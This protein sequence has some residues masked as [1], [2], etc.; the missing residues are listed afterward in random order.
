MRTMRIQGEQGSLWPLW[1]AVVCWLIVT[2][3][4]VSALSPDNATFS[5]GTRL[6]LREKARGMFY[7]GWDSYMDYAFPDDELR[8]LSC[9]G[10]GPDL[11]DPL[12][13]GINDVLG[14]YSVTLLDSLDMFPIMGDQK[15]FE[16]YVE[17]VR[18]YVSFNV[19]NS[20]QV[21]E[22]TIRAMGGLLSAHLYAS[23]P[24]LGH[25][26]P[27]Y[28]GH[29]LALAHDLGE[30]LLPAFETATG[31]PLPRV[32]LRHGVVPLDGNTIITETCT[33]GAGSLVLE[34][35][36]LSRLTDDPRFET[37]ARRAFY[38]IWARRS[39]IDLVGMALDARTG[40][41]EAPLT[42][43]GASID[44][45]YEYAMK[46]YVLFND[47]YSFK[48]FDTMYRK[49][50]EYSS[51]GWTFHNINFV[52]GS[53]MTS[54]TDALAAFFAS[55]QVLAGDLVGAIRSHLLYFK[56]WNTYG[57]IPER[58]RPDSPSI[59]SEAAVTLEWYPLRP[60]FIESNYY[61]YR[62]TQDPFYLQVGKGVMDDYEALYRLPC[63]Y[64]GLQDTRTGALADRMESF[65][66]SESVKYLYLLYDDDNTLHKQH[67][68]FVFSTEA[69]PLFYDDDV[70][71]HASS[72]R[73]SAVQASID[74]SPGRQQAMEIAARAAAATDKDEK[75]S[76]SLFER[77]LAKFGGIKQQSNQEVLSGEPPVVANSSRTAASG[78]PPQPQ[79]QPW[80]T[81]SIDRSTVASWD[82]FYLLDARNN[83][84]KPQWL[85]DIGVRPSTMELEPEFYNAYLRDSL[86]TCTAGDFDHNLEVAF[87]VPDGGKKASMYV[88][89]DEVGIQH[90]SVDTLNGVSLKFG[91]VE[92]M[93]RNSPSL[94]VTRMNGVRVDGVVV[95]EEL[96][97]M[98][99]GPVSVDN[100]GIMLV[101]GKPVVNVAI[102]DRQAS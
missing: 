50:L 64:A 73:F 72:P 86:P 5:R 12:N 36:L 61:I 19:S 53:P 2:P 46:N 20:V 56:L 87:M 81:E 60:E 28:D 84:T 71:L 68:N 47:A 93:Q 43:I 76:G 79:C 91:R 40:Q 3:S 35:T 8:P 21:F 98:P 26:I 77:W 74:A 37:A 51:D 96:N 52:T 94:R 6:A 54:W 29:L 42:G 58:W 13:I 23:V 48:V 69:H 38:Q 49:L 9:S 101:R 7:H 41:W 89:T 59:P 100:R 17:Y 39:G 57:G 90:V 33:S 22:T 70:L 82:G 62:A 31:I 66:L 78:L 32:N 83:F 16:K 55:V 10:R 65:F 34:F 14:G 44:S 92:D 45:Y 15:N 27:G 30:R 4:I 102:A 95:V 18:S 75:S 80:N 63:G 97:L 67:S 1:T 25:A 88:F 85:Q 24:R 99:S 11:N